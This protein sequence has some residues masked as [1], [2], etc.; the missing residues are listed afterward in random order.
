MWLH[1]QKVWSLMWPCTQKVK[2]HVTTH[3]ESLKFNV[4]THTEGLKFNLI[5]LHTKKAWRSVC[6]HRRLDVQC[7][8]C[9]HMEGLKFSVTTLQT[10]KAWRS[11]T[12]LQTEKAWRSVWP[13][14]THRRL[15]KLNLTTDILHIYT[16]GLSSLRQ[17]NTH[18]DTHTKTHAGLWNMETNGI[19]S[20][21]LLWSPM[22]TLYLQLCGPTPQDAGSSVMCLPGFLSSLKDMGK[23]VQLAAGPLSHLSNKVQDHFLLQ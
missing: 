2:F 1:V 13:L 9:T 8:H 19:T 23:R 5:S 4:T 12:T 18:M 10:Q 7:D 14:Y 15:L 17:P 6:I 21:E 16:E 22:I 20:P 11:V 3:T